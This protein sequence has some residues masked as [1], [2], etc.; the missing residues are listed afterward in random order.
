M[1]R[2]MASGRPPTDKSG[3]A[4]DECRGETV[5][6]SSDA[7]SVGVSGQNGV[8]RSQ[9]LNFSEIVL[10]IAQMCSIVS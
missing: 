5:W 4:A 3:G 7:N 1:R 8:T 6:M 2:E 10:V 9:F